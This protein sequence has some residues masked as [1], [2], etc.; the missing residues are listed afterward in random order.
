MKKRKR[1]LPDGTLSVP[2]LQFVSSNATTQ[3]LQAFIALQPLQAMSCFS[4]QIS[5]FLLQHSWV[6]KSKAQ[7]NP[8]PG[9]P[10][11]VGSPKPAAP[12]ALA[13]QLLES[14]SRIK[15]FQNCN[16]SKD[17]IKRD[18]GGEK[19]KSHSS[20]GLAEQMH[21]SVSHVPEQHVGSPEYNLKTLS[22][23]HAMQAPYDRLDREVQKGGWH[24]CKKWI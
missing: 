2:G 5:S 11:L 12:E 9:M 4:Y 21:R 6:K 8:D 3:P 15:V 10:H 18:A 19:I 13:L 14:S 1:P 24:A 23:H 17:G 7:A 22:G 16:G 20:Q